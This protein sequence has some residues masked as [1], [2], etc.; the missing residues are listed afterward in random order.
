MTHPWKDQ[1][2]TTDEIVSFNK[3]LVDTHEH[4]V[5]F[6][7]KS[8]KIGGKFLDY[9]LVYFPTIWNQGWQRWSAPLQLLSAF[10]MSYIAFQGLNAVFKFV[11]VTIFIDEG[12][13]TFTLPIAATAIV[14]MGWLSYRHLRLVQR[15]NE[16][17]IRGSPQSIRS[18]DWWLSTREDLD[19]LIKKVN[20]LEELLNDKKRI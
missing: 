11:G 1:R 4:Q 13:V 2:H 7:S 18:Y 14:V 17:G 20:K 8:K 10:S 16:L 12:Y 9:V 6:K 3:T 5:V 15:S 19:Y